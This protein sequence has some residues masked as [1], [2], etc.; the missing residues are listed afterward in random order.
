M[1]QAAAITPRLLTRPEAATYCGVSVATFNAVCPVQAV[2]MGEGKRLERYDVQALDRWIDLLN[3]TT[4]PQ[5]QAWL[6][7]L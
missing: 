1:G 3:G 7:R 5:P 4:P 6:D 2:A